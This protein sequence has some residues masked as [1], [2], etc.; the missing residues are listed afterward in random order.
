M[1]KTSIICMALLGCLSILFASCDKSDSDTQ[2]EGS[3]YYDSYLFSVPYDDKSQSIS[4]ILFESEKYYVSV[5]KESISDVGESSDITLS[6]YCLNSDGSV[7]YKLD[8]DYWFK[9]QA[10]V[11]DQIIYSSGNSIVFLDKGTGSLISTRTIDSD[12]SINSIV[13]FNDGFVVATDNS[14]ILFDEEWNKESEIRNNKFASLDYVE[15]VFR[16][17]DSYYGVFDF[18]YKFEFNMLDFEDESIEKVIDSNDLEIQASEI[19]GN[20]FINSDGEFVVDLTQNKVTKLVDWSITDIMPPL[21]QGGTACFMIDDSKFAEAHNYID[22][23]CDVVLYQHDD[24]YNSDA[25]K[26]IIGGYNVKNDLY[27]QWAKY[28]YN[29]SHN[30]YRI[31]LDDYVDSYQGNGA[32]DQ[33]AAITTMISRFNDGDS[34]DIFYGNS[35]DYNMMADRGM[36]I[37][38]SNS[39]YNANLFIDKIIPSVRESMEYNDGMYYIFP[40]FYLDGFWGLHSVFNGNNEVKYNDLP[41]YADGISIYGNMYN[42]NITYDVI[43]RNIYNLNVLMQDNAREE[44]IED[45]INFSVTNGIPADSSIENIVLPDLNSITHHQYLLSLMIITGIWDVNNYEDSCGERFD[46]IG[47]PSVGG[48]VQLAQGLGLVAVSSGSEHIEQ[49]IDFLNCLISERI[50]YTGVLNDNIPVNE[51]VLDDY[52]N[53]AVHPEEIPDDSLLVSWR[54]TNR[55]SS[56]TAAD[57]LRSAI[58]SIDT[59]AFYDWGIYSIILEEVSSHDVQGKSDTE[60]ADALISRLEVYINENIN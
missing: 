41:D 35:F 8:F 36:V 43:G 16:I 4:D 32:S 31:V 7:D 2:E 54:R 47:Y 45:I 29:T 22:G 9:P 23:S 38:L 56:Q 37:D 40:A 52:I 15:P 10:I 18:G 14:I 50:Q 55:V 26:I 53:S 6:L 12:D 27:I 30:D 34:P 3:Y 51:V 59:V 46:Y 49:C 5:R 57:D 60:V 28:L 1:R 20:Y 25:V 48:S 13:G 42:Y 39:N 24:A 21:K 58:N 33:A 44:V 19:H 17:G 11:N